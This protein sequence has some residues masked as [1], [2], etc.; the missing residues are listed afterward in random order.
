LIHH[1]HAG[2]FGKSVQKTAVFRGDLAWIQGDFPGPYEFNC[3]PPWFVT[4]SLISLHLSLPEISPVVGE[5]AEACSR[6][7]R[8]PEL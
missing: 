7:G 1:F 6:R 3:L 5:L 2:L 8:R 4:Q